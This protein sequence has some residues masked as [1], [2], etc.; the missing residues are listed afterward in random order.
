MR[1]SVKKFII[2]T[3]AFLWVGLGILLAIQDAGVESSR[4]TAGRIVSLAPNLTEI[5]FALGLDDELAAVS[6]DSDYPPEADDK[7]KVGNFW[8]PSL[9]AIISAGPDLVVALWFEQQSSVARRLL[10]KKPGQFIRV[11]GGQLAGVV[12]AE[13]G[14]CLI[15]QHGNVCDKRQ[16]LA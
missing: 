8:Q 12:L 4:V 11:G 16:V 1:I 3:A 13:V 9:E 10:F 5:L 15:L 6:S 14:G 7:V 2:P